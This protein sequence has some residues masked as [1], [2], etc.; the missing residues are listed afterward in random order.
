M[1]YL[2]RL[3]AIAEERSG[4]KAALAR[5]LQV[6]HSVIDSWK[7]GGGITLR[8]FEALLDATGG[9]IQRALPW[10]SD[11]EAPA[12][13]REL[14]AAK[15]S[16]EKRLSESETSVRGLRLA[17]GAMMR[18]GQAALERYPDLVASRSSL[19]PTVILLTDEKKE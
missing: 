3:A 9:D 15:A 14:E 7:E 1:E 12:L 8:N 19:G 17:V 13:V 5:K 6:H 2:K 10:G 18:Q 4:G 16:A 11:G